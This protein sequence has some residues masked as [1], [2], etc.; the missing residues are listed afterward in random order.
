ME[1]KFENIDNRSTILKFTL[2]SINVSLA[3]ALRRTI[4]ADIPT[5]VIRTELYEENNCQIAVNTS[6]L[7]NEIVKH[8]LSCIPIYGI[9]IEDVDLYILELDVQNDSE[10]IKY[11][12]TADF[13][14]RYKNKKI[15]NEDSDSS[16]E[17]GKFKYLSQQEIRQ[18]FPPCQNTGE[19]SEPD[20]FIDFLRLRPKIGEIPGEH[21][22]LTA[23]F[24][25]ATATE[26]AMFNV[27]SKC[28]YN[29]TIDK[30]VAEEERK[31]VIA[32][33][34]S[35]ADA[36]FNQKNFDTLTR[37][38]YFIPN[39]FDFQI[40]TSS[41]YDNLEIVFK[42]CHVLVDRLQQCIDGIG[43]KV[44]FT[45]SESLIEN[46]FDII[47]VGEDYTI[48]KTL[49][50]MLYS[51]FYEGNQSLIFCGFS[52]A[53]PHEN[54][55]ILRIAFK[56]NTEGSSSTDNLNLSTPAAMECFLRAANEAKIIFQKMAKKIATNKK[57][58]GPSGMK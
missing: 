2:S 48:G 1:P 43:K 36:E 17:E 30:K 55:C 16:S 24:S 57:M 10:Q 32:S 15:T 52:K 22:K 38:R 40:E 7:H 25:V 26:N 27:V 41:G 12:T 50:Y 28:T 47:L 44:T 46:C 14:I 20:L 8:R 58:S 29:N 37:A 34:T 3:N 33:S 56:K 18:V 9:K 23:T 51:M 21:I 35:E 49:E 5:V 39:S 19:Y 13:K 4:I 53:H 31:K 6:R 42:A 11:V 54:E 45:K